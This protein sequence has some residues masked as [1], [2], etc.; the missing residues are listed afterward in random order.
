MRCGRV[1]AAR[2]D[3]TDRLRLTGST[4]FSLPFD[5]LPYRNTLVCGR[6]AAPVSCGC[7]PGGKRCWL[8]NRR[9]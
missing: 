4:S 9:R 2:G 1:A 6:V 8:R 3:F 5:R 7:R